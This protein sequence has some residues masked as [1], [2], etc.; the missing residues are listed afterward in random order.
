M[1]EESDIPVIGGVTPLRI[2]YHRHYFALGEHY[3]S[4]IVAGGKAISE[5]SSVFNKLNV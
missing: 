5:V 1:G 4:V 3:N 2:S